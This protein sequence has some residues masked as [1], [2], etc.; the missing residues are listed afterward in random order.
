MPS[1]WNLHY[2]RWVIDDGEPD[3]AVGESFAWF[4]VEFWAE[5]GPVAA[6][7]ANERKATPVGDFQYRVTAKVACV[8]EKAAV[9]DFGLRAV[10]PRDNLPL[11]CR[12]GDYITGDIG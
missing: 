2:A 5:G 1:E 6:N 3:R 9:I 4:A 8:S 12:T 11:D 10:G 7:G